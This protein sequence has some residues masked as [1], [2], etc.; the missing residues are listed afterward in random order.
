METL[1]RFV[2]VMAIVAAENETDMP[3]A[4]IESGRFG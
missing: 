1:A 4:A 2:S 3:P